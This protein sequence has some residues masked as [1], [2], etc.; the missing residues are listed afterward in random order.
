MP[1]AVEAKQTS[2]CGKVKAPSGGKGDHGEAP[3]PMDRRHENMLYYHVITFIG[4]H[5]RCGLELRHAWV[6][7][8]GRAFSR[9]D[10][11]SGAGGNAAALGLRRNHRGRNTD[12]PAPTGSPEAMRAGLKDALE[13]LDGERIGAVI[14]R[15]AAADTE[16]G[17][18][19][20]RLTE[21]PDYP[22][23]MDALASEEAPIRDGK[24]I[25]EGT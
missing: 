22:A 4:M 3:E 14:Q 24:L 5:A 15:I 10:G 20:A 1:L 12:Y 13:N 17:R 21:N 2:G 16:L 6:Y 8:N 23:I 19:L 9:A 18:A 11:I 7:P 25:G